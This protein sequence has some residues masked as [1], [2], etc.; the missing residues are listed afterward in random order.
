MP[1]ADFEINL[2]KELNLWAVRVFNKIKRNFVQY[3]IN[4]GEKSTDDGYTGDLYRSMWWTVH[5]GAGGNPAFIKFFYMKY[6]DFVEWGV[7]SRFDDP[8]RRGPEPKG[9]GLWDVPPITDSGQGPIGYPEP[10]NKRG[11]RYYSKPWLRREVR[12]HTKWLL[13]RLTEQY[14]YWGN[15]YTV[16]SLADGVGDKSITEKWI[17]ENKDM[18]TKGFLDMMGFVG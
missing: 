4:K 8:R 16:R 3:R 10:Y 9:Q 13:K 5:A 6:G 11:H 7:G 2:S 1:T 18:L 17:A 12:Y 15:L 14:A